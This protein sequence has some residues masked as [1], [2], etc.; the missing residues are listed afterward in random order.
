MHAPLIEAL[1]NPSCYPHAV[2]RVERI[3]THISWVLL[4]GD[5]VYKIKKPLDLG[6]LD[7]T[8]LEK[9]KFFCQE[10]IRLNRRT[11]PKLYLDAVPITGKPE[12]P[13]VNGRG[14]PFEYAV[15]MRR[16]D[17]E[18]TFDRLLSR[19]ELQADDVADLAR[20]LAGLHARAAIAPPDSRHGNHRAVAGPMFDNFTTLR[21]QLGDDSLAPVERWTREQLHKLNPLIEQRL[22]GGLV[23]ECH[24]DAHL[25]NVARID[26]RA[27]LFD[28]IEFNPELRWTDVIC[29]LAFTVMDL[30]H[31]GADDLAWLLL[32]EYSAETGDFDGM[33]L[34]SL[35]TTYRALVRAKVNTFRLEDVEADREQVQAGIDAYLALA[36]TLTTEF[37][38]GLFVTMGVSGSG[39]SWLA[40]RLLQ[41]VGMLRIRSDVERKRLAGLR[42]DAKSASELGAQ[43]YSRQAGKRTYAHLVETARKL[44]ESGFPVLVDASCLESWQREPFSELAGELEI[45][46]GIIECRAEDSVLRQRIIERD[47]VGKD[48]SE[49]GLEVLAHQ[50]RT[51]QALHE[52]ERQTALCL[53][54]GEP[55][56]VESA[57]G[58]IEQR[59]PR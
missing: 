53:D 51:A 58:W 40:R 41:R 25:G 49:A 5:F 34:L 37:R 54:T 31:R 2:D 56:S 32:D 36:A 46:F 1:E 16:F 44:I 48:P 7:F 28:C 35:Y 39:K 29:D 15:R 18:A 13:Q 57:V 3:E 26:G 21:D 27:T 20:N 12:D 47:R 23:R 4:A 33:R 30:R 17:P 43:L 22:Q 42:P 6:F 14:K 8:T 24:G 52:N 19:R 59:L 9:R 45:P 38:P 10:E 50:Q 11:A 55:D